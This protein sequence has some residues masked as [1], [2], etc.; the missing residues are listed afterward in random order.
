MSSE[1]VAVRRLTPEE[2][3]RLRLIIVDGVNPD[4]SCAHPQ[5]IRDQDGRDWCNLCGAQV[6]QTA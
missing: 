2:K 1:V 3:E 6:S 5:G 4:G